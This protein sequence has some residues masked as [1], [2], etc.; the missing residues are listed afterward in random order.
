M[1]PANRFNEE[2]LAVLFQ[3]LVEHQ[4][5]NESRLSRETEPQNMVLKRCR[6]HVPHISTASLPGQGIP[7]GAIAMLPGN[8]VPPWCEIS[9]GPRLLGVKDMTGDAHHHHHCQHHQHHQCTSTITI[10]ITTTIISSS[11]NGI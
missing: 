2:L 6:T 1:V 4:L 9:S 10:I 11:S 5:G 8:G 3:Y 7:G